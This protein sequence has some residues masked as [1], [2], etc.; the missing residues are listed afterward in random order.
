M[1]NAPSE[2][3]DDIGSM[4]EGPAINFSTQTFLATHDSE[5]QTRVPIMEASTLTEIKRTFDGS[6]QTQPLTLPPLHNQAASSSTQTEHI[7]KGYNSI[8]TQTT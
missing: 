2:S 6:C 5:C 3:D 8:E 4:L 7:E 1:V